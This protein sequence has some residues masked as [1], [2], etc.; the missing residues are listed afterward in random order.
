MTILSKAVKPCKFQIKTIS[1]TVLKVTNYVLILNVKS[2]QIYLLP[3]QHYCCLDFA[4]RKFKILPM[5]WNNFL[6]FF[7]TFP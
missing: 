1:L 5:F 2:M 7:L 4:Q 6:V 3:P